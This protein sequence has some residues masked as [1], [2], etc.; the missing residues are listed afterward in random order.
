MTDILLNDILKQE[1]FPW[2]VKK[3]VKNIDVED[4]V[5]NFYLKAL[6]AADHGD[7]SMLLEFVRSNWKI[8]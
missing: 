2:D 3:N 8:L 4:E 1:P 5:R 7:Y 6:R